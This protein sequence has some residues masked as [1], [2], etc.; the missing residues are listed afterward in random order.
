MLDDALYLRT[1]TMDA[2]IDLPHTIHIH[3]HIHIHGIHPSTRQ[4]ACPRAGLER[5]AGLGCTYL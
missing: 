5:L 1:G 3:I 2:T 4:C